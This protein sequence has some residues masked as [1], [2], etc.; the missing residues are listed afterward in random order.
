M[1]EG[2]CGTIDY[3]MDDFEFFRQKFGEDGEKKWLKQEKIRLYKITT[4]VEEFIDKVNSFA[5]EGKEDA[6]FLTILKEV[7]GKVVGSE[8]Q[9]VL[10]RAIRER[11]PTAMQSLK[12]AT[13][14]ALGM[15][16]PEFTKE[17]IAVITGEQ[18]EEEKKAEEEEEK[19]EEEKEVFKEDGFGTRYRSV[20]LEGNDVDFMLLSE[21]GSLHDEN[22]GLIAEQ[23]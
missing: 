16:E 9:A 8:E 20:Q 1:P 17:Q 5:K 3:L 6:A 23:E 18:P 21:N 7:V 12:N 13:Y 11:Q 22:F 2:K 15:V 19:K 10:V 14:E 4:R